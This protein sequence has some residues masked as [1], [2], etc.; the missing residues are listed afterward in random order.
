[1]RWIPYKTRISQ[2][3]QRPFNQNNP[4]KP[5]IVT[6]NLKKMN[7]WF[8]IKR[9]IP[10]RIFPIRFTPSSA[11]RK[12]SISCW[13]FLKE[14][15]KKLKTCINSLKKLKRLTKSIWIELTFPNWFCSRKEEPTL[16]Y[17]KGPR[18]FWQHRKSEKPWEFHFDISWLTY[19]TVGFWRVKK[20]ISAH[21]CSTLPE[22]GK[23]S[24]TWTDRCSEKSPERID[25]LKYFDFSYFMKEEMG[26][27]NKEKIKKVDKNIEEVP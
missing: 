10:N 1:M 24:N 16:R 19:A 6:T 18:A 14:I 26:G 7:L 3:F 8:S 5:Q 2:P 4:K 22:K 27:E 21:W 15:R 12:A 20:W 9:R 11:L 17:L 25:F 13:R 23:S